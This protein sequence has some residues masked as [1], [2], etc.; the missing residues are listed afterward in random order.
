MFIHIPSYDFYRTLELKKSS[1]MQGEDVYALQKAL[2]ATGFDPGVIDGILGL[3]TD[4]AV[5][6]AQTKFR[7]VV[8]GLAGGATQKAL[9]MEIARGVS[10]AERVRLDALKG[11]I[12]WESA[13]FRL[14]AY[15]PIRP[16]NSFDA[17][18][19]Q[20]NT[21]ETPAEEGFDP[22]SSIR[23]LAKRIR[24]HYD[25][26]EGV[27]SPRRRWQLAQGS[28]NAPAY[29]CYIARAEGATKVTTAMTSKPSDTSRSTLENYMTKVSKYLPDF[30]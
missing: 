28:W 6:A 1:L 29:A 9:A 30:L 15:S 27:T 23:A 21:N 19:T 13:G 26:F 22:V 18:I 4:T 8:D 25:L 20:R 16:D 11:Q 3:K 5:R 10:D 2:A 12:E 7:L 14:G 24:K 17:G